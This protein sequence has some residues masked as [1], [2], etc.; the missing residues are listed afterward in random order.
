MI[1]TIDL[2]EWVCMQLRVSIKSFQLGIFLILREEDKLF[3]HMSPQL[4][5]C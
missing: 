4:A 2:Q 3:P 1:L 5:L